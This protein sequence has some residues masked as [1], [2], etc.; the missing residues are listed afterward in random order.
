MGTPVGYDF[1]PSKC[2]ALHITKSRHPAQH[3]YMLHG[4]ALEAAD[5]AK[6]LGVDISKDPSWNT[7]INRITAN[8]SRILDYKKP[9]HRHSHSSILN[10]GPPTGRIRLSCVEPLHPDLCKQ[11]AQR[12]MIVLLSPMCQGQISFKKNIWMGHGN[13]RPEIELV[14]AFMPV[15]VTSNFADDLIKNEWASMEIPFSHY[16]SMGN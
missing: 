16:K 8:A 15:L 12:A 2:Q 11:V 6:Y 1:N 13:Q 5:H 9:T 7:H 10:T 14:Q 3:V 4:Q